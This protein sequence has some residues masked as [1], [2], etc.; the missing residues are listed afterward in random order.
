MGRV[1]ATGAEVV[2]TGERR[3]R[4][5][6]PGAAVTNLVARLGRGRRPRTAPPCRHEE[7]FFLM[8]DKPRDLIKPVVVID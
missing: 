4:A 1:V 6:S 3:R 7:N 2:T 8:R 5:G